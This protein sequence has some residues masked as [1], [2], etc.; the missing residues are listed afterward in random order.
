MKL[1]TLNALLEACKK[2]RKF[3]PNTDRASTFT[4]GLTQMAGSEVMELCR[5]IDAMSLA[6]NVV[7]RE[8][9]IELKADLKQPIHGFVD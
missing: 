5:A 8:A 2:I 9:R 6:I 3:S 4:T 1:E 7:E